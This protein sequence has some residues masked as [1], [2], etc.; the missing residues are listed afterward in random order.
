MHFT[1]LCQCKYESQESVFCLYS[2]LIQI[3]TISHSH[4]YSRTNNT[5]LNV[6]TVAAYPEW[7]TGNDPEPLGVVFHHLGPTM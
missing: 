4:F 2:R 7:G 5:Q 1:G 3:F 6:I